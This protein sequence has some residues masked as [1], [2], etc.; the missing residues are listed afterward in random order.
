MN[1]PPI[2]GV[3]FPFI[4]A[5]AMATKRAVGATP[6]SSSQIRYPLNIS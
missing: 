2:C 5:A 6:S 1:V 4:L 3:G